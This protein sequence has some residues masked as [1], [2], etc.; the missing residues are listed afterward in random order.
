MTSSLSLF[1]KESCCVTLEIINLDKILL[2]G[3][4]LTKKGNKFVCYGNIDSLISF[5]LR[6]IIIQVWD[7]FKS[8]PF[9]ELTCLLIIIC[10]FIKGPRHPWLFF[11]ITTWQLQQIVKLLNLPIM[12]V[13]FWSATGKAS[14]NLSEFEYSKEIYFLWIAIFFKCS[15]PKNWTF[16][17]SILS[18][19]HARISYL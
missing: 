13:F 6:I 1:G 19:T 10:L 7:L 15:S 14:V 16:F 18:R 8:K 12:D 2:A 17:L 9:N 3:C 5:I 4:V 11:Y